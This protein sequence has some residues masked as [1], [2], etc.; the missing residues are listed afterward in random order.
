[1]YGAS[2]SRGHLDFGEISILLIKF[3]LNL[4]IPAQAI[5]AALSPQ[6][7]KSGKIVFK[8]EE[9]QNHLYIYLKLFINPIMNY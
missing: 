4:F 7:F 5:I 1:M 8:E 3:F 9:K 6:N 2:L